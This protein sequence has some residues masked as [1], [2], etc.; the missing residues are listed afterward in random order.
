MALCIIWANEC[1]TG[2]IPAFPA[3][4]LPIIRMR[5][6]KRQLFRLGNAYKID[7]RHCKTAW[8]I[9]EKAN[10]LEEQGHY[11]KAIHR[12]LNKNSFSN[13]REIWPA[14]PPAP[15]D[16]DFYLH[17][18]GKTAKLI[19]EERAA[20]LIWTFQVTKAA[21]DTDTAIMLLKLILDYD[22]KTARRVKN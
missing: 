15:A 2:A 20:Q 13:V 11:K 22:E 19:S 1:W 18:Q 6:T 7:F 14:S 10:N 9:H 4:P 8:R 21:N 16:I 12:Y 17:V 3:H 5:T